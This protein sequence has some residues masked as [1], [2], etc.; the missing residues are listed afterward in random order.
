MCGSDGERAMVQN[1]LPEILPDLPDS[2]AVLCVP[3]TY[4][5]SLL[6]VLNIESRA[7]NAFFSL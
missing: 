2:R 4:G 1:A 3:I 5:E 6:G 7:E